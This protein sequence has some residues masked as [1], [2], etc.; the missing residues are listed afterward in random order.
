MLLVQ[1]TTESTLALFLARPNHLIIAQLD[2]SQAGFKT[3]S[4]I[5]FNGDTMMGK[6]IPFMDPGM[7]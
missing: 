2:I 6:K 1:M 5:L 4:W 7:Q 3:K